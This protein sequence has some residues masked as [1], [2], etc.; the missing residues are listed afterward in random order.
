MAQTGKNLIPFSHKNLNDWRENFKGVQY[1]HEETNFLLTGAVD[2]LWFD[3]DKN[4]IIVVDYKATSKN[5]EVT[6]DADWQIGYRRQMDFYQWLIRKNGFQ[7]SNIGYF[8]Y[9]NGDKKRDSF[10]NKIHFD[11]S[12]LEYVG[13][14]KWVEPTLNEIKLLLDQ[15]IVPKTNI[16]CSYCNYVQNVNSVDSVE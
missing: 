15:T 10:E 14:T 6:I 1:F 11:V 7:V 16:D 13:S 12:V 4:E 9:C 5:S 3:L 2:D 8:V